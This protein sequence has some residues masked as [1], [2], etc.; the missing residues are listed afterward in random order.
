[1]ALLSLDELV[2]TVALVSVDFTEVNARRASGE[3]PTT[4]DTGPDG[5]SV[6]ATRRPD[7]IEVRCGIDHAE[8]DATYR[9]VVQGTFQAQESFEI[10]DTTMTAFVQQV[11]V[12]TL[13]PYL[14]ETVRGLS[15]KI[16]ARAV[17]L[18]LLRPGQIQLGLQGKAGSN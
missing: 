4:A 6:T 3:A 5:L 15:A 7:R 9:V 13:Y 18:E 12:M 1:M 14:R 8:A 2:S 10:D 11:G 17:L 16:G